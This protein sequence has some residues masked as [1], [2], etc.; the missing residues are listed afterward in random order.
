MYSTP[1]ETEGVVSPFAEIPKWVRR[2]SIILAMFLIAD[3]IGV[4]LLRHDILGTGWLSIGF[5]I[6]LVAALGLLT[7]RKWGV[8]IAGFLTVVSLLGA[9]ISIKAALGS[10][11]MDVVAQGAIAL[12][13]YFAIF[14][15]LV[16]AWKYFE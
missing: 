12:I 8:I 9:T 7:M 2:G 14:T 1:W 16:I 3:G 5:S 13:I 6:R 15:Y 10:Q 11:A 4:I